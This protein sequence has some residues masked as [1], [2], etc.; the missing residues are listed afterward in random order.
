MTEF[1]FNNFILNL[2]YFFA[3]EKKNVLNFLSCKVNGLKK[4]II[5]VK[6]F[7]TRL[8]NKTDTPP[9]LRNGIHLH[10]ISYALA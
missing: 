10:P 1:P 7:M 8:G 6:G 9:L 4:L 3:F 5:I 2:K